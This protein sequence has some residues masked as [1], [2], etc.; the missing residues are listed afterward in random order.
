MIKIMGK[1]DGVDADFSEK[2]LECLFDFMGDDD[3][4]DNDNPDYEKLFNKDSALFQGEEV[5]Y[6]LWTFKLVEIDN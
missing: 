5:K 4:F 1:M 6:G 3:E 2:K